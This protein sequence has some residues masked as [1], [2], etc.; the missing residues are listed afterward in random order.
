MYRQLRYQKSSEFWRRKS[1]S[2]QSQPRKLWRSVE[3]L[4]G[5]VPASSIIDV[6]EFSRFSTEKVQ[7]VRFS[8]KD[9]PPPTFSAVLACP[10]RL[11][12]R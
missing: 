8:I 12:N 11:S 10:S 2:D 7:K 6:E 5:R 1:E 3:E 9:E 4:L